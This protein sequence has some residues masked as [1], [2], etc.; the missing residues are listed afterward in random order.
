MQFQHALNAGIAIGSNHSLYSCAANKIA[1]PIAG[2]CDF[3]LRL[4]QKALAESVFGTPAE[5]RAQNNR[6][7]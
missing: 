1:A 3:G 2:Y 7:S 5:Q 4:N 6:S